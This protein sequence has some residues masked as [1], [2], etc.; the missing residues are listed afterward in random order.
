[1]KASKIKL[2]VKRTAIIFLFQVL[3]FHPIDDM[4]ILNR[5]FLVKIVQEGIVTMIITKTVC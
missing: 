1:M 2:V 3:K 4:T 5:H